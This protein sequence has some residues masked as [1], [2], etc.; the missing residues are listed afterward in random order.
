MSDFQSWALVKVAG[1]SRCIAAIGCKE[2]RKYV[3]VCVYKWRKESYDTGICSPSA[4]RE[5]EEGKGL[6]SEHTKGS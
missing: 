3:C 5:F 2:R 4:E 6:Y 1:S